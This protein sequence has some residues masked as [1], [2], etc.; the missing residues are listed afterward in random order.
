[1]NL[2]RRLE[3]ETDAQRVAFRYVLALILMRK[4]ML[5]YDG[6]ETKRVDVTRQAEEEGT[7]QAGASEDNADKTPPRVEQIEQQWWKLT[8]KVDVSKGPLG[9]WAEDE[10]LLVLDPK[11]DATRITEIA[12]QLGEILDGELET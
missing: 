9:K 5:R 1:M 2:L 3:E 6:C 10:T 7:E 4:K 12:E 8:P 11:L